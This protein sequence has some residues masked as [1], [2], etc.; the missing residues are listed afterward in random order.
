[1]AFLTFKRYR[2]AY[3]WSLIVSGHGI[4]LLSLAI[5][6]DS[7]L[8]LE[9]STSRYAVTAL[10]AIGWWSMVTGQAFVLWSRLHLVLHG[11]RAEM[12]LRWTKWMIIVN[13]F[14]LHVPATAM[15]F[16]AEGRISNKTFDA[17]YTIILKVEVAGF[18]AQ[19]TLLSLI[20]IWCAAKML[21]APAFH[22]D[23]APFWD[24]NSVILKGLIAI[25][26]TIIL[27]DLGLV[28]LQSLSL[29]TVQTLAKSLVY[30][31]KLKLE[32]AVLRKL[33]KCVHNG[34]PWGS[35]SMPWAPRDAERD[36]FVYDVGGLAAETSKNGHPQM[37]ERNDSACMNVDCAR[38]MITVPHRVCSV[39]RVT[40]RDLD[41]D[42][43]RFRHADHVTRLE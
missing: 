22:R 38:S 42:L 26:A 40:G 23:S 13:V 32:F 33:K 1:M 5:V 43:A 39:A 24:R 16:V 36:I 7:I 31:V 11:G 41:Y 29:S 2:G 14:L 18:F 20:Y 19:E 34:D 6:L 21:R 9:L 3:F 15:A 25:N 27:L 17:A 4:I 8:V 35:R 30:A 37:P 12:T 28:L 10:A